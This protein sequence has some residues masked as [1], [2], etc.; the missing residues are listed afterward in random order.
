MNDYRYR[1]RTVRRV[2]KT[3]WLPESTGRISLSPAPVPP[4]PFYLFLLPV[5]AFG[6]AVR[7]E[8]IM[9][10][11]IVGLPHFKWVCQTRSNRW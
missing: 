7:H 11:A 6:A 10:P 9:I 3:C 1:R 8:R 4:A 5:I 2:L